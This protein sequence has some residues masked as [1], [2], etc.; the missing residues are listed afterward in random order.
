MAFKNLTPEDL[1]DLQFL[2]N[3]R[4]FKHVLGMIDETVGR[5]E[6]EVVT[7]PISGTPNEAMLTLNNKRHQAIGAASLRNA[8]K[9][10]ISEL[11]YSKEGEQR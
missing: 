6:Q 10:K 3:H 7:F 11:R 4:A 8:L 5:I 2:V 9:T 1:E